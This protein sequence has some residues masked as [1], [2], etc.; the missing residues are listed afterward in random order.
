MFQHSLIDKTLP[1]NRLHNKVFLY[2]SQNDS[3]LKSSNFFI[4]I[5]RFYGSNFFDIDK[6]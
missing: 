6:V 4:N 2:E 1:P 5:Y 3:K